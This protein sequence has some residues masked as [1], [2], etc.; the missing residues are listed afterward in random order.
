MKSEFRF[1]QF[2]ILQEHCAMKVGTDGVLLGAWASGGKRLLDI[3]TGTGLIALMMA[4]RFPDAHVD[5]IEIVSE[6]VKQARE[7]IGAS[8]F[9]DRI[10][11]QEVAIQKYKVPYYDAIVSNPPFFYNALK[12]PDLSRR[13]ARHTDTLSYRELFNSVKRLLTDEGEFSAVIPFDCKI[14]FETEAFLQGFFLSREY[15]VRTTSRKQPK[16]FLL[17]F[18]KCPLRNIEKREVVMMNADNTRSDWYSELTKDFY[19]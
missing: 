2:R 3:G 10:N 4:Q 8:S 17:A 18:R 13:K 7:N 12:N 14:A 19:L 11:V 9:A 15:A 5:A 1:Q 6:A 16:R